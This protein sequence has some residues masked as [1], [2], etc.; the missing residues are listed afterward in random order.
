MSY[1]CRTVPTSISVVARRGG[2]VIAAFLL[3]AVQPVSAVGPPPFLIAVDDDADVYYAGWDSASTSFTGYALIGELRNEGPGANARN[4]A[5]ADFD[6]DGDDDVVVS[7]MNYDDHLYS[8]LFLNNGSNQFVRTRAFYRYDS[9]FNGWAMDSAA[10]DLNNDGNMDLVANGDYR[11]LIVYLGDGRGDFTASLVT[12]LENNARGT[13]LGDFD[14]DGDLDMVRAAYSGGRVRL[15]PGNGDGTFA[16][17]LEI[18]DVG[19]DPYGVVAG[20]FDGD[21]HLD[22]IAN[23]GGSGDSTLFL[24]Q[25]DLSFSNAGLIASVDFNNH[26]A[27]DAFDYDGDGDLDLVAASHTSRNIYF[28]RGNG[29]GTFTN[30][31]TVG[32]TTSHCLGISAPPLPPLTNAPVPAIVPAAQTVATNGQANFDGSSSYDPDG[33]IVS[34]RWDFGDGAPAVA[35]TNAPGLQTHTYTNEG[36]YYARLRVTDNDT[37]SAYAASAVAVT[38]AVPAVVTNPLAV[39]ETLAESSVWPLTLD[40]TNHSADGEGLVSWNWTF[41]DGLMED[42]EDGMA[43]GWFPY[44]G[45]W[46]VVSNGA[47][48]G[49]WSYRQSAYDARTRNLHGRVYEGDF[50]FETDV[51][52]IGGGGEEIILILCAENQNY[53]Y[54]ILFRGRGINDIRVDEVGGAGGAIH[55][56]RL[57]F[58][59]GQNVVYHLKVRR[60]AGLM[61]FYIDSEFITS[62]Y[63]TTYTRGRIGLC[64]WST[65]LLFDNVR[66]TPIGSG[67]NVLHTFSAGTNPVVLAVADAAAQSATGTFSVVAEIGDPP[68]ADAGGPYTVNETN[69]N[70][71]GEGWL[72]NLDGNASTDTV[73]SAAELTYLWDLGTNTFDGTNVHDGKWVFSSSG[74][75]Q[76]GALNITGN[77]DWGQRY[78]FTRQT[79]PRARGLV[80]EARIKQDSGYA[81]VGF[82]NGNET[83]QYTQMPHALYLH[84]GEF[85]I[86]ENGSHRRT[87]G[88]Y[89]FNTWYEIR[90]EVKETPGA[91]YFYRPEGHPIWLPLYESS[92]ATAADL[93]VG[94]DVYSGTLS[95]DDWQETAGGVSPAVRLYGAG[96]HTVKLTVTDPSGAW[97]SDTATVSNLV[98]DP[99]VADAGP[100]LH[101]YESNA[102]ESVW[103]FSFSGSASTDDH[104]IFK[105]Q[106]DWDNDGAFDETAENA[107]HAWSS[108]GTNTVALRVWDHAF[109]THTDT[110]QV[111][112]HAGTLPSPDA[113][114]PYAFDEFTNGASAG[115]W[116]VSV[117]GTNSTDAE[118]SLV[119]YI[120]DFG[121]DEFDDGTHMDEKWARSSDAFM[122]NGLLTFTWLNGNYDSGHYC[123]TGDSFQRE[124]GLRVQTRIRF[125]GSNL[126]VIFGFKTDNESNTHWNQWVYGLHNENGTL[127]YVESGAHVSF[128]IPITLNTWYDWRIE[129]K[130]GSGARYYYKRAD[131]TEW[132]LVRDSTHSSESTFRR[133]YHLFRGGFEA[134]SYT[135]WAA[136]VTPSYRLYTERAGTNDVS[137]TVWDQALNTNTHA[138]SLAC[139]Y[140]DAPVADA[141]V[142]KLGNESNAVEGIWFFTFDG[143]GSSDDHGIYRYEWD[144]DYDGAFD[145]SGDEGVSVV[146]AFPTSIEGTNTIALRV[147]DHLMQTN[148]DTALVV[149]DR[150]SIPW[151]DAG[152]NRTV[153]IG[154]PLA[155]DGRGSTD[156]VEVARFE[157]NFG[158]GATGK[159]PTPKHIYRTVTNYTVTLVVYDR[160]EQASAPD[161]IVVNVVTSTV[162]IAEAGGPYTAGRDGPPAYLDGRNS[163]D[164]GDSNVV[165]GIAVYLWDADVSDD[166]DSDGTPDNDADGVW[167]QSMHLY[168]AVG[169]YTAK[170]TVVDGAG[171][172][173]TDLAV[174]NVVSNLAPHVICVPLHGD[175]SAPHPTHDGYEATLKGVARDAGTL[176]YQWDFGDGITTTVATVT[177]KYAIEAKHSYTG[178]VGQPFVATLT[179]WDSAGLSGSDTYRLAIRQDNQS[180]RAEIAKDNGLWWL[181]NDQD[182]ADGRW[183]QPTENNSTYRPAAAAAPLQAL[184]M[185]GHRYEGELTEDPYVETVR[186]GFGYLFTTLAARS[187]GMQTAGNP[188]TNGNG[189]GIDVNFDRRGYQTGI[190]MDAIAASQELL[191]VAASGAVNVKHRFFFDILTDMVDV[192]AWGQADS[193]DRYGGWRYNW[194]NDADNSISQWGGI[195][196]LAA[197]DLFGINMPQWVRDAN[198]QWLNSSFDGT[199]Y[200]YQPNYYPWG[201]TAWHATQP[202]AMIQMSIDGIYTSNSTWRAAENV[203]ASNWQT[204][205]GASSQ[206]NYYALYAAV[207]AL[208]LA[209]P[210]PITLFES[211]GL[212]WYNDPTYGVEQK[213]TAHQNADGSWD[214]WYRDNGSSLYRDLSTAWGI[215]MLT[216]GVVGQ[217]PVAVITAPAVWR[218]DTALQFSAANSY[219][220]DTTRTIVRYHWDFDNDGTIDFQTTDPA[221]PNAVYTWVDP[222]PGSPGDGPEQVTVR[223]KVQDDNA[224]AVYDETT[225]T[226]TVRES[227]LAPYA[228]PGGPYTGGAWAGVTLDGSGSFDLDPGDQVTWYEW[229]SDN[230]GSPELATSNS[231][232]TY[233]FTSAGQFIVGLRVTDSGAFNG[234]TNLVSDWAYT[235]ATITNIPNPDLDGDGINDD[236]ERE[237]FGSTTNADETT[238]FDEDGFLDLDESLA[239]TDATDSNSLLRIEALW[240][241][242][243]TGTG[244]A[245][246]WQSVTTRWYDVARDTNLVV[247][248]PFAKIGTNIAGEPGQTTYYDVTATNPVP[249]YY[250]IEL[251]LP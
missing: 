70:A 107:T 210:R 48:S 42:F 43:E 25:G 19:S 16:P 235:T 72:V 168:D 104:G 184:Q 129:L 232:A 196:P 137:L 178:T 157:W 185:N 80:L 22:V 55:G 161:S 247:P 163:T 10:G 45:A 123:F 217:P 183:L 246:K 82:K 39:G 31:V 92:Y 239:D 127:F 152:S 144:W 54:E 189:L 14:H 124:R 6:N 244:V 171:H 58:P 174:V 159:G 211:S 220:I 153:E 111:V 165:Q 98:N 52:M 112:I 44:Q 30:G 213:V 164:N 139:L 248:P 49:T 28:Y 149:L 182:R 218:Y 170:L 79:Y 201:E 57:P 74:V 204:Y 17:F 5:I 88:H 117:Q 50:V 135:E 83:Y 195:G 150:G 47:I 110:C 63:D 191:G 2:L 156:D 148:V 142:D 133:G 228:D 103:T 27:F 13:D 179:V 93:K 66:V 100:D 87:P 155:F 32:T 35:T 8:Y 106:W 99:P 37:N 250:R 86:Y 34:N 51:K 192:Y 41:S 46:S 225:I 188:D 7:R 241:L 234:G 205:Y 81:M 76:D 251:N 208:R 126:D 115:A 118:S 97:D 1:S 193:G 21:G 242:A 78:C 114:G 138:A 202:S 146:H 238:D 227:P 158:D 40:A 167:Q 240:P 121:D 102:V 181:H 203:L 134:D 162:P 120:W 226:L 94:A 166:S 145:P 212:D 71:L 116:S 200:R 122:T 105:Y 249:H 197:E 91:R 62:L 18:G 151:A 60:Q 75:S 12:D 175:P 20:D 173:N 190:A 223:L 61:E 56:A 33:T 77:N 224:P 245:V 38:G 101:Q 199:H 229:D 85:R 113:G 214:A 177:D 4:A 59:I 194:E 132:V 36:L 243:P 11:R 23:E 143:S 219:H 160:A 147:S 169:V 180:T 84:Y 96:E 125:T 95:I 90:I 209:R 73:S 108:P 222:N 172:T 130:G 26:G 230:D 198:W 140:N 3:L 216:P 131:E 237:T 154:Y 9:E 206:R 53:M 207:K 67:S 186:K 69:G 89:S 221:D 64:S 128:G 233:T 109:Q 136:G 141:G 215:M 231:T 24:G 68:S 187:I 29:D 65:D 176:T 119:Q 236:W 15:Y